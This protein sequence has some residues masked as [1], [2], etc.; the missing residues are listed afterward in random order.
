MP[1]IV[2]AVAEHGYDIYD[3]VCY[4]HISGH[5]IFGEKLSD[6]FRRKARFVADFHNMDTPSSV[7]YSTVVSRGLV[8]ICLTITDLNGLDILASDI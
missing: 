1:K 8:R 5:I 3:L 2:A 7:T 4:Q 6:K